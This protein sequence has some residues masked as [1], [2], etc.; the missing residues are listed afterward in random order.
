M[1]AYF[2]SVIKRL[3][4][5]QFI[6]VF[7]Y[8]KFLDLSKS[9]Y[10]FKDRFYELSKFYDFRHPL[11]DKVFVNPIPVFQAFIGVQLFCALFAVLGFRL[12]SFFSGFLMFVTSIVYFSPFKSIK[13]GVPTKFLLESCSMEFLFSIALVLAILAQAFTSSDS[14][15]SKSVVLEAKDEQPESITSKQTEGRDSR[16][17]S[18]S[19]KAG[20]KR[21]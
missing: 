18:T 6:F 17:Q 2:N 21:L 12:F 10:E 8:Y 5:F 19:G 14:K 20:K 7:A 15:K 16:P 1:L 13:A 3:L 9:S 11:V 4:L